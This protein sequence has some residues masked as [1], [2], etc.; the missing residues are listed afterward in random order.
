MFPFHS[1]TNH[2]FYDVSMVDAA[3]VGVQTLPDP[4]TYDITTSNAIGNACQ[5]SSDCPAKGNKQYNWVCDTKIKKCVN[6]M[7]CGAPGCVD[8]RC[9]LY[10]AGGAYLAHSPWAG[11]DSG[12]HAVSAAACP[13]ELEWANAAHQYVACLNADKAC[14]WATPSRSNNIQ[15]QCAANIHLYRC[16]APNAGSCFSTT[17]DPN[18]CG[19]PSWAANYCPAGDDTNWHKKAGPYAN[20]FH[21]ASPT[22][23]S[24]P[25]DDDISTFTCIGKSADNNV[26]YTVNFCPRPGV[27]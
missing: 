3:N 5:T 7:E 15:L 4:D 17:K 10:G 22:S 19:C 16:E 18:C 9:A 24:F 6:R 12:R 26:A 27:N 2:D 11:T 20:I 25:Y 21:N 14:S 1:V 8:A 23:Y 13:A